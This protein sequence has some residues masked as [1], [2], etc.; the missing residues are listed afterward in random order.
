MII[1][2]QSEDSDLYKHIQ[3]TD[4]KLASGTSFEVSAEDLRKW[5]DNTTLLKLTDTPSAY[6][7][8]AG[9]ALVVNTNENGVTFAS[10]EDV[11]NINLKEL[12][13]V[14]M[15]S[16]PKEGD[17]LMFNLATQRWRLSNMTTILSML[18]SG[19][20]TTNKLLLIKR[21][22]LS[23]ITALTDGELGFTTD[24][25]QLYIGSTSGNLKIQMEYNKG[26]AGGYA[27]L[28]DD[29]KIPASFM[30]D[31]VFS[32]MHSA[33]SLEDM[34][35]LTPV[36]KGD[37]CFRNDENK[38]YI[39]TTGT[40][41]TIDDWRFIGIAANAVN[42][43]M[44]KT[45]IVTLT[46]GEIG[47][48]PALI[49]YSAF[50]TNFGITQNEVARGNH[51]H[52]ETY[53][54]KNSNI[55]SHISNTTLHFTQEDISIQTSQVSGLQSAISAN[56]DLVTALNH[57]NQTWDNPHAVTKT[58][59]GLSNVTNDTQI[60]MTYLDT[61]PLLGPNNNKI[62]S[63]LAVKTYADAHF[64]PSSITVYNPTENILDAKR[65]VAFWEN[66][67]SIGYMSVIPADNRDPQKMPALGVLQ[68]TIAAYGLAVVSF[69]GLVSGIDTSA[70]EERDILFVGV[71]GLLTNEKPLGNRVIQI[72]GFVVEAAEDGQIWLYGNW[73]INNYSEDLID[74]G[75]SEE[76][77]FDEIVNPM[78]GEDSY[79]VVDANTV[80]GHHA[81]DFAESTHT[82]SEFIPIVADIEDACTIPDTVD[83]VLIDPVTEITVILPAAADKSGKNLKV[84]NKG[85]IQFILA[86][87]AGE[88]IDDLASKLILPKESVDLMSDGTDWW[89]I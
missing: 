3:N 42:S 39:N 5:L 47:A 48:E 34:L 12:V 86:S 87:S 17:I 76:I 62:A 78:N 71:D 25:K 28:N 50:N 2:R 16:N 13:D 55:Q 9:K 11:Y 68:T 7:G 81:S 33:D 19:D 53:E 73:G 43:V 32:N 52:T 24:E 79:L 89:I 1:N 85:D 49:K 83:V 54:A 29:S 51:L 77:D 84:K 31:E 59:I 46:P 44:G 35:A 88:Y 38:T 8:S 27:P 21:G 40:N 36:S 10:L 41:T 65:V 18:D 63:Q 69:R 26:E 58:H 60:P 37:I 64:M 6:S 23:S 82:H 74:G 15:Q 14:S 67:E 45:G 80:D 4:V 30:P 57:K 61:N 22:A 75:D 56:T 72:V 20:F 66:D 70:F